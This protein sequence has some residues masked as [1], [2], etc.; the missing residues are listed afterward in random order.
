VRPVFLEPNYDEQWGVDHGIASHDLEEKLAAYSDASDVFIISPTYYGITPD[1]QAF[2]NLCHE[3][4]I[5]L[6]VDEAWEPHFAFT[7]TCPYPRFGEARTFL[8]AASTKPWPV[9]STLPSSCSKAS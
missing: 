5:P 8:S 7:R 2:A 4:G 1:I 9:W 3:R 6:I